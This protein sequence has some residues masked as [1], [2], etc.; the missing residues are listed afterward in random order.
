VWLLRMS[1]WPFP[2]MR[3]GTSGVHVASRC[4]RGIV[5][6]SPFSLL[7]MLSMWLDNSK[8]P[9]ICHRHYKLI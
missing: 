5:L 3:A 9:L 8:I 4:E 7:E 2:E 6:Q 1:K